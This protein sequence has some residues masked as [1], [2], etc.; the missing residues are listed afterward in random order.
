MVEFPCYFE[1]V[2]VFVFSRLI[3]LVRRQIFIQRIVIAKFF[4]QSSYSFGSLRLASFVVIGK[5]IFILGEQLGYVGF[6]VVALLL[7]PIEIRALI[8]GVARD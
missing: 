5:Q 1:F 7:K 6:V 8:V 3:S 2:S 4:I